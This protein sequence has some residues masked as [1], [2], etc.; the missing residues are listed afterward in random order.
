MLS[1]FS[2]PTDQRSQL[3]MGHHQFGLMLL[4]LVVAILASG[5]ALQLASMSRNAP[6]PASAR[7]ALLSGAVTLAFGIWAM[8]FIGMLSFQLPIAVSYD[9]YLTLASVLP[10]LLASA[11]ALS[12]LSASRQTLPVILLGGLLV[13]AGIGAMHYV[14]MFAM[15]ME[16]DL[17]YDPV[18]FGVS[19]VVAVVMAM[20]ALWL[21]YGLRRLLNLATS[22]SLV[23][24]GIGMGF[25]ITSMH[26]TG[27]LAARFVGH[28]QLTLGVSA[29]NTPL[30][31]GI[32]FAV[33]A[34]TVVVAATNGALRYRDLLNQVQDSEARLLADID[35]RKIL[36]QHLRSARDQAER[37]A[38]AKSTFLANMSHEIRTPMNAII[39]FS[40][41]LLD[42]PL[43]EQQYRHASTVHRSARSLLRL[44]NDILDTA[45][46][47]RG[48][49]EL[50]AQAFSL[51][52]LCEDTTEVLALQAENKGITLELQYQA[53]NDVYLGD[54]LRVRQ[55]LLNLL[56]N[57][58]KFTEQ[59]GVVLLVS[60][61]DK[62]VSLCVMDTGI[63]IAADRLEAI[64][65]PFAQADATMSRRFGGTGLGTTI[66]LQ[67]AQL[68]GGDIFAESTPGTGSTFTVKLPLP[69][70]RLPEAPVRNADS[71]NQFLRVLAVDDV[72]ENLELLKITLRN[73]G[74]EVVLASNGE[75]AVE[76]YKQT[77][78]DLVLMDVQM[79]V[80]DG[81]QATKAIREYER[82]TG[83]QPTAVIALTA[84]VMDRDRQAARN[85]GMNGFASK[86]LDRAQLNDE[87][88]KVMGLG[89]DAGLNNNQQRRSAEKTNSDALEASNKPEMRHFNREAAW[90][91]WGSDEALGKALQSFVSNHLSVSKMLRHLLQH[92]DQKK[93]SML[94]HKLKGS[95]GNLGLETLAALCHKLEFSAAQSAPEGDQQKVMDQIADELEKVAATAQSEA[96]TSPE[97]A[98]KSE[99]DAPVKDARKSTTDTASHLGAI[100]TLLDDL[101]R[102]ELNESSVQ[103][104]TKGLNASLQ[105]QLTTALDNF[106]FD[107]AVEILDTEKNQH[108]TTS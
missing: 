60:G 51:R 88:E 86:P 80:M 93:L 1:L 9:P 43:D 52:Q 54:P 26:Y 97:A 39:G 104:V 32:G 100:N 45:K 13:G 44:L 105:R 92:R 108:G 74:H 96:A 36:E 5:F 24:G 16:A 103:Q 2:I 64:F 58:V 89:T 19:I 73:A 11:I 15:R 67:L 101:R 69:K 59:G 29:D 70:A 79:P 20:L 61:S 102:G 81:L 31:L 37:A 8:H 28:E 56:S 57:A 30:A 95:A 47:E 34:L 84:S 27:M 94:L 12:I 90:Q 25:A 78:F 82:E 68:M 77:K 99:L 85:A 91:R 75:E 23:L 98:E 41:L 65:D 53:N 76:A 72:P 62:E 22:T 42:T 17:R 49:I 10:A 55:V 33:L 63:G 7:I 38:E 71:Q 50:E 6:S 35:E 21:H 66:A 87:I 40:E 48:A 14:G 18:L 83:Q 4:S 3:L 46:L 107:K 106:D